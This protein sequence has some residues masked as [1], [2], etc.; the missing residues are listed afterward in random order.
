MPP[1]LLLVV[2]AV[3]AAI[4]ARRLAREWKRINRELERAKAA[5]VDAERKA[6]TVLQRD[7]ETGVYSPNRKDKRP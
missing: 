4:V 5:Q 2:G 1:A 6:A 7:P 3:G